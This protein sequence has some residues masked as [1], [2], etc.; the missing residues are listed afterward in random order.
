METLKDLFKTNTH[1]RSE[2]KKNIFEIDD[3]AKVLQIIKNR[4]KIGKDRYGHGIRTWDDTRSFGTTYNSWAEMALE[5]FIDGLVYL[6]ASMIRLERLKN[7][8]YNKF[9]VNDDIIIN[10]V[11]K[12]YKTY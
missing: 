1:M 3:N 7:T 5:E 10:D 12:T 11:R 2:F 6:S 9:Q 8:S 4:M